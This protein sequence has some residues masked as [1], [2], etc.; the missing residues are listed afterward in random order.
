MS[1]T[2][3]DSTG[4]EQPDSQL[5][6]ISQK[7]ITEKFLKALMNTPTIPDR[8]KTSPTGYADLL[9]TVKYGEELGIGPFTSMYQVYLVNGNAS[10]MGQLMLA[11]VWAAGHKVDI[12]IDELA[13]KVTPFRRIDGEWHEFSPVEFTIED[14]NRA[15]LLE[16]KGTYEKYIKH[17]L[18]WRA[19]A[20]ACRLYYADCFTT[21]ALH[22]SE[23]GVATPVE[24]L[25]EYVE[26]HVAD[27]AV[28]DWNVENA[29]AVLEAEI[30][31]E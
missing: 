21:Q 25:P 4:T 30:M 1:E 24:P 14:A 9:A 3:T 5:V 6:P 27:G 19:V 17:M 20:L 8:F 22:P 10:L 31:D 29:G 15:G 18:A 28:E 7:P 11:K 13:V 2:T 12:Q 23:V 16:D 26:V